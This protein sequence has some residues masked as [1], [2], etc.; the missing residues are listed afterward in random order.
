MNTGEHPGV[1]SR[2]PASAHLMVSSTDRYTTFFDRLANPTTASSWQLNK[3]QN[4][5]SG[6]FT[7]LAITQIQFQ[8]NIP[9]IIENYNAFF[10]ID[11]SGV[12]IFISIPTGFYTPASLATEIETLVKDDDDYD[13]DWDFTVTGSSTGFTFSVAS[14]YDFTITPPVVDD[15]APDA[16]EFSKFLILIGAFENTFT[17]NT[18]LAITGVPTMLA[19]RWVDICSSRLTQF[20]RVKDATT[21]PQNLTSDVIARVYAVPPGQSMNDDMPGQILAIP[22]IF[23]IDY[24]T[25][26]HIKW[27]PDQAVNNFDV[28]VFDEY[29]QLMYWSPEYQTEYQMTILASE[30]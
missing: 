28:Q 21:L 4:I 14:P 18:D 13:E 15:D 11:I 27:S 5:L 23:C 29:G 6:Y 10:G 17:E 8:W 16:I 25:P 2:P 19:T 9:T 7:R 12:S 22:N 26:K 30:T 3:Q 1:P 24:N 20:Q